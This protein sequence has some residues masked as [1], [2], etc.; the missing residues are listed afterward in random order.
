MHLTR[1]SEADPKID[2]IRTSWLR[3]TREDARWLAS[4]ADESVISGV[5]EPG[6]FAFIAL[7]HGSAG[8]IVGPGTP[9][10]AVICPTNML[11]LTSNQ[12]GEAARRIPAVA[13]AWAGSF[14][15]A[16]QL[17]R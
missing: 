4:V 14:E 7:D 2:R 10:T 17:V 12:L 8:L 6:N 5:L 13:D 11:V 15:G 3:P 16:A 1:T 9:P